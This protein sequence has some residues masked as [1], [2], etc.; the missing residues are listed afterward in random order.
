MKN[1][2]KTPDPFATVFNSKKLFF[3]AGP[4]VIES[5]RLCLSV[6]ERLAEMSRKKD[7]T[8]IFK[9]SYDKA[10]RTSK[11]SFRGPGKKAGLK[12]LSQIKKYSGLPILTDIHETKDIE[13]TSEIVDI[14]QIP[15]FL[16]RQT[17]LLVSAGKT[18]KWINVKK[19]QFMS[20]LDMKYVIDKVGDKCIITERG[21][22]FG[23]NRLV[24]D[25]TGI[26]ELKSLGVPVI[27]DATHSVQTPGG[28][29]GRS[30]G[31]RDLA[32]PLARAA[33]CNKVNGLF[34]EVHPNPDKALCDGP[35]S[36]NINEFEKNIERLSDLKSFIDNW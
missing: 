36:L 9:A 35:N 18:N 25:F 1:R 10:N 20:P 11:G 13:D 14:L 27:F 12:I 7:V 29:K 3:I 17:D 5:E 6:A 33:V 26:I 2:R 22:F 32:I 34:F 28:Q 19:G 15:A 24:V 21:T 8:I 23:Y 16:C 30:G 31:N 4:C